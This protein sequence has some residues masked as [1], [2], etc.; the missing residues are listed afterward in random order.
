MASH[1]SLVHSLLLLFR[2]GPVCTNIR[3]PWQDVIPVE[4]VVAR[5]SESGSD[6]EK[7]SAEVAMCA[8]PRAISGLHYA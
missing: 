5:V 2:I 6:N 4:L 8:W 7:H 3:T 1:G